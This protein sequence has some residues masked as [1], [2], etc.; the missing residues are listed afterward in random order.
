[1]RENMSINERALILLESEGESSVSKT[2]IPP[3]V[4]YII[5]HMNPYYPFKLP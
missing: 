5:K 4:N 1:M 3:A 2:F